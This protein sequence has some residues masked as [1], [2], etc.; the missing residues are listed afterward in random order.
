MHKSNRKY[1]YYCL[2]SVAGFTLNS[3]KLNFE[4]NAGQMN[5]LPI[6]RLSQVKRICQ[7]YDVE[8]Q[9]QQ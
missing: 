9:E 7:W 4:K 8:C 5:L 1:G 3:S 2:R 6:N